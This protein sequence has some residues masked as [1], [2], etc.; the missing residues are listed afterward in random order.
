MQTWQPLIRKT[1]SCTDVLGSSL[2]QEVAH[3]S[4]ACLADCW[5]SVVFDDVQPQV[6]LEATSEFQGSAA[7]RDACKK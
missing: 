2:P 7:A 6:L 1:L 5:Q 4:R 3:A